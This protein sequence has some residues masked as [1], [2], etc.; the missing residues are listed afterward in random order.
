MAETVSHIETLYILSIV[1]QQ[2]SRTD[3]EPAMNSRVDLGP[4][5]GF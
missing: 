2:R 3:A 1:I 4:F 5:G